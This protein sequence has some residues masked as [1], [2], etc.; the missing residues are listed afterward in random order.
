MLAEK[1]LL[2]MLLPSQ[3]TKLTGVEF[4]STSIFF[5]FRFDFHLLKN[6][7]RTEEGGKRRE[8]LGAADL[9]IS[10]VR[11]VVSLLFMCIV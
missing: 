1:L 9:N 5:D 7:N 10:I 3:R 8:G 6:E 11:L 2:F 4:Q